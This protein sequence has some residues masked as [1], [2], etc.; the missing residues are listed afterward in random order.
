MD[1]LLKIY[2]RE[3]DVTVH[4][5]VKD[6][7]RYTEL[8]V[9]FLNKLWLLHLATFLLL[10]TFVYIWK[11]VGP[12]NANT[13]LT[14]NMFYS[15]QNLLKKDNSHPPVR[16]LDVIPS[17]YWRHCYFYSNLFKVQYLVIKAKL[18]LD[19][20]VRKQLGCCIYN[21]NPYGRCWVKIG[22]QDNRSRNEMKCQE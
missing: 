7:I 4:R 1:Q 10:T 18:I 20:M 12:F 8:L 22:G 16:I 5:W 3:D 13:S 2:F 11:N 6:W 17:C 19:L 14:F 15:H 21:A 9:H